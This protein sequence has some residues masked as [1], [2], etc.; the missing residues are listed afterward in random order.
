[1]ILYAIIVFMS[2]VS[3]Y[4]TS[5]EVSA[6]LSNFSDEAR[7]AFESYCSGEAKSYVDP[8]IRD[9][10]VRTLG[11]LSLFAPNSLSQRAYDAVALQPLADQ[12]NRPNQPIRRKAAGHALHGYFKTQNFKANSY[13]GTLFG[14]LPHL[15]R[16]AQ[17]Y[18]SRLDGTLPRNIGEPTDIDQWI[19]CR[20]GTNIPELARIGTMTNVESQLAR[21]AYVNDFLVHPPDDDELLFDNVLRAETFYAPQLEI[22][23]LHALDMMIQSNAAKVRVYKSGNEAALE[24]ATDILEQ[25]KDI[26]S[27]DIMKRFFGTTPQSH[28]FQTSRESLYDET[29]IFSSTALEELTH[30]DYSGKLNTRFKSVG[31]YAL[32][33][34]LNPNYSFEKDR[35]PVDVFGMLAVLPNEQ[36][37]GILL[38][39]VVTRAVKDGSIDL[40]TPPSKQK[41]LFIQ[42]TEDYI[43]AV[44][45]QIPEEFYQKYVQEK[46]ITDRPAH[47]SFQV[48]KF[49][50]NLRFGSTVIP[51]E[52]QFQTEKDRTNARLGVPSHMN[53]NAGDGIASIIPGSPQ[54]L[55]S[56]YYRKTKVDSKGESVNKQSVI[57]GEEFRKRFYASIR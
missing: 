55:T 35:H 48:A 29:I 34:L 8:T 32:K 47:E 19:S 52:F 13:V 20:V 27:E 6:P 5:H 4:D 54:A 36:Q 18:Q 30:G 42:G 57:H 15:D 14:D 28:A 51:V 1:M 10:A 24:H 2:I 50:S 46:I 21:A 49:Y 25:A 22:Y 11:S 12:I 23:G 9:R 41:P 17:S 44:R 7:T 38:Y 31:K 43:S 39:D 45:R 26:S 56:L 33:S 37:V 53:H 40:I 3:S 16:S